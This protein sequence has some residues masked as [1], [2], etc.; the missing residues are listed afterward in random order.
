[1]VRAWTFLG[2]Q[3]ASQQLYHITIYKQQNRTIFPTNK[4]NDNL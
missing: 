1:M 2:K 4:T 3:G